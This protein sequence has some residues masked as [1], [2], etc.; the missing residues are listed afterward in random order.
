M[1]D[2]QTKSRLIKLAAEMARGDGMPNE[3]ISDWNLPKTGTVGARVEIMRA[4]KHARSQC[5]YWSRRIMEIVDDV[6]VG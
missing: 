4:T 5:H 3:F 6:Q 2:E 1:T